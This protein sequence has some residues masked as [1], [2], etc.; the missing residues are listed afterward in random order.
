MTS[1]DQ[2]MEEILASLESL[3][4]T[5][6]NGELQGIKHSLD[7]VIRDQKI[8]K[9]DL[10]YFK[11]RFFNPDDGIIVRVNK[12]TDSIS[13]FTDELVQ[14]P[15]LKTRI[16]DLERWRGVINKTSWFIITTM[17]GL[18]AAFLSS[19]FSGTKH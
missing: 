6:P 5:M 10:D 19:L 13:R 2:R 7:S 12:N 3:K 14:I 11:K 4:N 15:D 1:S 16:E 9:D 8:I 17:G 18:I